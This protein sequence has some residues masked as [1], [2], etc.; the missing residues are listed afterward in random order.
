LHYFATGVQG[1]IAAVKCQSPL[2]ALWRAVFKRVY[3]K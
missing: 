3:Y 1:Y 2:A